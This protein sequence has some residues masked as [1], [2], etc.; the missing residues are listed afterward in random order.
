[1]IFLL[2]IFELHV[3][4]SGNVLIVAVRAVQYCKHVAVSGNVLIVA[5]RAVQYCKTLSSVRAS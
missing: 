4:V 1:M 3:A 2:D 5:V